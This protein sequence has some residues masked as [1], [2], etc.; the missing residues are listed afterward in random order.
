MAS[1]ARRKAEPAAETPSQPGVSP[2]GAINIGNI[3]NGDFGG[4]S[5]V[6][7]VETATRKGTTNARLREE[8]NNLADEVVG[9]E[10]GMTD[11]QRIAVR[12]RI[13]EAS[14]ETVR[15]SLADDRQSLGA[16]VANLNKNFQD[17]GEEFKHVQDFNPDEQRVIDRAKQAHQTSLTRISE[18]TTELQEAHKKWNF[19]GRRESAVAEATANLAKMEA[20]EKL[21]NAA[22]EAAVKTAED[23]R[24]D[25]LQEADFEQSFQTISTCVNKTVQVLQERISALG[26]Q[27]T[28]A[29]NT[30][31][32]SFANKQQAALNMEAKKIE[33]EQLA[34][35]YGQA[36]EH[37]ETLEI[38][39]SERVK[40]EALVS[41]IQRK[42][43]EAKA[44]HDQQMVV[45]QSMEKAT[46]KLG[47]DEASLRAGLHSH[48]VTLA[49]LVADSGV[50]LV[51]FRNRVAQ[52]KAMASQQASSD[53]IQLGSAVRRENAKR[54]A[55][56]AIGSL[57]NITEQ[58]ERH[59]AQMEDL[60][61]IATAMA[62][63]LQ[64]AAARWKVIES[65]TKEAGHLPMGDQDQ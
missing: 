56:F 21:A 26:V 9:L 44:A 22:I 7:K 31:E 57:A 13:L 63:G 37:R 60:S 30:K 20:D 36:S 54:S 50:W 52:I 61:V 28:E 49:Q 24:A 23:M 40:Q 55:E 62:E 58:A 34:A 39:S 12:T 4:G 64:S 29:Q 3:L 65:K 42:Y 19:F 59:P 17:I 43:D 25:R 14:I 41:E 16:L 11:E 8:A 5:A 46:A 51:E 2:P 1:G 18:A 45:F 32:Q 10:E 35:E 47:I 48:K 27:A 38:G 33:V 15:N 6:A 53:L